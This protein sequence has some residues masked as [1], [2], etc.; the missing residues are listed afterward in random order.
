ML[1]YYNSFIRLQK[2]SIM[3]SVR[4][5]PPL[6]LYI[7]IPW[8]VRKCPY[9]DFNSH[10]QNSQNIPQM[11]Y[12]AAL[13]ADLEQELPQLAEREIVS[14]FIGGG[15]PSLLDAEIIEQLLLGLRTR[16]NLQPQLE[17]TLEANPGTVESEKFQR[18]RDAGVNRLS[19]G[20]QSFDTAT[21][22]KLGRIHDA[23][24]AHQAII[25]AK[26]ARFDNLNLDLMFGL[27]GQTITSAINELA[28]ACSFSPSHLSWYQ[29]TIE[30][31]TEFY[32]TPPVLPE[33]DEIWQIQ[34]AGLEFLSTQGFENYE[35][36]AFA[37]QGR[38]C[39]HNLNYWQFGDYIGIG[40]GAHGKLTNIQTGH[41]TRRSKQSHPKTYLKQAHTT[42]VVATCHELQ[43]KDI[44]SEFMLNALRLKQGVAISTFTERTRLS[45]QSVESLVQQAKDRGW[46]MQED[47][48]DKRI[49][50]TPQGWQFLNDVLELFF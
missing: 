18:F 33:E 22:Q 21:L 15:T 3:T 32:R 38:Y 40:A 49:V 50:A 48:Q 42:A 10:A 41:I 35:I 20:I 19:L 27:P 8:C 28:I 30:P 2:S 44:I 34:Q 23:E 7:H 17:I 12:L 5:V 31:H 25:L 24:Q 4:Q 14:I 43:P 39:Q 26:Q 47:Q 13:F 37:R 6:S 1:Q 29:L 11:A 16:L 9:C 36:S 45:W 46:L